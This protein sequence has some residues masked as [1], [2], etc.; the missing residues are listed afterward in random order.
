VAFTRNEVSGHTDRVGTVERNLEL[1]RARSDA[2]ADE[3]VRWGILRSS[4]DIHAFGEE[5]P[6]VKTAAGIRE[7]RNRRVEIVY[8]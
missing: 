3:M 5:K 7:A 1:S 2:V 6:A 4:I 8:R